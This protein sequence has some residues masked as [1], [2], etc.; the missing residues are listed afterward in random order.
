MISGDCEGV[1][2]AEGETR[3]GGEDRIEQCAHLPPYLPLFLV[4]GTFFSLSLSLAL[5][6]SRSLLDRTFI[7]ARAAHSY[8]QTRH[9][10]HVASLSS[11]LSP[12]ALCSEKN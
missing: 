5:A 11:Q 8:T 10:S 6:R 3:G 7:R 2:E 9:M 12:A 4:P 1:L